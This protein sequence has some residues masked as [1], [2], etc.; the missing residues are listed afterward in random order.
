[1]LSIAPD[2]CSL[3]E[4]LNLLIK[5]IEK[6]S[7]LLKNNGLSKKT[8]ALAKK[9]LRPCYCSDR[10]KQFRKMLIEFLERNMQSIK[11]GTHPVRNCGSF[12]VTD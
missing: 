4:E 3:I 8:Y 6:I 5:T 1:M 9:Y 7:I 11:R 2:H 10:L 12:E